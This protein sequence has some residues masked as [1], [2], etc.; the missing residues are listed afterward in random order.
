MHDQELERL[1]A[2]IVAEEE[3]PPA[4]LVAATKQRLRGTR[5]LS[6]S[7]AASLLILSATGLGIIIVLASP[8]PALMTKIYVGAV[9]LFLW[10]AAAMVLVAGQ[11]AIAPHLR[12]L[13]QIAGYQSG[14]RTGF[15]NGEI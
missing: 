8:A 13:E 14:K 1:I 10:G 15:C 4:A 9:S 2:E 3:S 11:D 5:L 6:L 7:L 12:R